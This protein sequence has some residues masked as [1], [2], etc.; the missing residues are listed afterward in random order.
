ML[1]LLASVPEFAA[2]TF[3]VGY[4]ELRV[5]FDEVAGEPRNCDLAVVCSGLTGRIAVSVEGKVE[6]SVGRAVGEEIM[7]AGTQ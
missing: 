7:R 5:P 6:V 3:E 1:A 2:L 4:P